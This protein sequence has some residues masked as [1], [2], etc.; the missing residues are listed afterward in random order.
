MNQENLLTRK[1][2]MEYLRIS[3]GTLDKL[4]KTGDL[5]FIKLERKLLFRKKDVDAWLETKRVK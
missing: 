3:H 1:D 5:P 2:V 4:M